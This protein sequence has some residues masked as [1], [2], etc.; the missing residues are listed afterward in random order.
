MTHERGG[1]FLHFN[2]CDKSVRF[3]R[4]RRE[5]IDVFYSLRCHENL[6]NANTVL[7]SYCDTGYCDKLLIV[8]VFVSHKRSKK[9]N[10]IL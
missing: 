5:K 9:N 3:P 10:F 7:P 1:I 6:S 4:K 8:T 2:E